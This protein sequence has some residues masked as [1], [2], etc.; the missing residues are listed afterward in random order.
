MS[1][2]KPIDPDIVQHN[3]K[4][5]E[6]FG[7][8]AC[9]Q[10]AYVAMLISI[11]LDGKIILNSQKERRPEDIALILETLS[12]QLRSGNNNLISRN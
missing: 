11:T 1:I 10:H 4:H 9:E 6:D 3:T 7:K 5:L 2:I 8:Y 12:R